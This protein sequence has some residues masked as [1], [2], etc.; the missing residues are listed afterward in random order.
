MAIGMG[1]SQKL[2]DKT[3]DGKKVVTARHGIRDKT[4]RIWNTT[5]GKEEQKLT[6]H[7]K[8][9]ESAVFSPDGKKIVTTS[10][11]DTARIWDAET[12]KELQKLEH[13][14]HVISAVFSSDGKKIVT[15]GGNIQIFD[16]E[17]GKELQTLARHTNSIRSATFSPDGKRI[18]AGGFPDGVV[19]IW[20]LE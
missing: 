13:T 17:S 11:D 14:W 2:F 7:I 9:V 1:N 16:V 3:P 6:G 4:A 12:G 8:Q 15:A 20:T 19:R 10:E 5:S 18:V